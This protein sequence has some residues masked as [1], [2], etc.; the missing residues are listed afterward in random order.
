DLPSGISFPAEEE[1]TL[2]FWK[3]RDTFQECLR[4]SEGRPE[5]TFYDGPPFATG[6]PHFGHILAGKGAAPG[7]A[8]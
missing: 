8:R 2:A 5:F 4:I 7:L 1:K 6:L 3:E